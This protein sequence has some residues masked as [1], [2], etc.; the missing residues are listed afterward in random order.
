MSMFGPDCVMIIF[1][2]KFFSQAWQATLNLDLQPIT[3]VCT[4]G[5]QFNK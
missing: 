3:Y 1:S 4:P 5:S 2:F